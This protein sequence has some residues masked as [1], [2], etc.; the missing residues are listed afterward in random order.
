M[1]DPPR[2]EVKTAIATCHSA[3][4]RVVMITGDHP[5]TATAIARDIGIVSRHGDAI[6]G[7]ELDAMSDET[8]RERVAGITVYAR[9]SAAHKL[10]IIRAW[11]ANDAVVA[12]TGD[13]VN[14]APAIKEADIGIAMGRAGTEV[15]KQAA[16]IVITDDNFATIVSAIEEGR[17][18]YANIRKTL[19]YLLAGNSGEL[20]LMTA[21]VAMGLPMPLLPIHLLWINLVTDG[22]PA[23][24]LAVD[25]IDAELMTRTPRHKSERLADRAFLRMMLFTGFITAAVTFTV[26]LIVLQS[27][28]TATAR[29]WAFSVL[30]FAELL[31]AFGARS[32]STVVWRIPLRTNPSL[33]LVIAIT[34]GVQLWSQHSE[35]LGRFLQTTPISYTDGA[36]L[37]AL[38]AIPLAVLELAKVVR[39]RR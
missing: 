28:P 37:L 23:L 39:R 3:G 24:S 27:Q 38:G 21:C 20:L 6:S 31:R 35:A 4:I 5:E 34:I 2:P 36:L 25:P 32:E 8:L 16:D 22:I 33:L 9:V 29:A 17:G 13:G 11:K 14:D 30:V 10:R 15:T 12:M 19:Q 18:I 7:V 1:H 26:Y